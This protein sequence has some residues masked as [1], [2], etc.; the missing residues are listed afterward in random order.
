VEFQG[1]VGSGLRSMPLRQPSDLNPLAIRHLIDITEGVTAR[2]FRVLADLAERPITLG[3]E[4]IDGR[5]VLDLP[6]CRPL[7]G[8]GFAYR[9]F[10]LATAAAH[11]PIDG[12]Y[13]RQR[14]DIWLQNRSLHRRT[15][16]RRRPR[17]L[18]NPS[19][20]INVNL[21]PGSVS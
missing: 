17:K 5:A 20:K 13:A 21:R 11:R 1:L 2:V 16:R 3:V 10:V 8:L 9:L 14:L 19:L 18:A 7:S 15:E 12:Q 6:L 4:R